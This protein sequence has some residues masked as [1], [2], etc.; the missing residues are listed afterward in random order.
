MQPLDFKRFSEMTLDQQ[1]YL[2]RI[3]QSYRDE[4]T[5]AWY[6]QY[7]SPAEL[8]EQMTLI[9]SPATVF[10]SVNGTASVVSG[11]SA[12]A[13]IYTTAG[14]NESTGLFISTGR[15]YGTE[16]GASLH[17]GILFDEIDGESMTINVMPKIGQYAIGG[18]LILDRQRNVIGGSLGIGVTPS[19]IGFF[20]TIFQNT[21]S[22]G[23]ESK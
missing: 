17:A 4:H 15:V 14:V 13:G 11:A 19:P 20:A 10:L 5:N 22:L 6:A 1:Q 21:D 12:N 9:M 23:T 3:G 16:L 2:I 18:S 8:R 7:G